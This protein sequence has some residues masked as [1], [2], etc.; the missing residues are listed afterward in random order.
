MVYPFLCHQ[1]DH[2]ISKKL[3]KPFPDCLHD[4]KTT[5][6]SLTRAIFLQVWDNFIYSANWQTDIASPTCNLIKSD[7]NLLLGTSGAGDIPSWL[8]QKSDVPKMASA[9][10]KNGRSSSSV[11]TDLI[12]GSHWIH[13][14]IRSH[15]SRGRC[16]RLYGDLHIDRHLFVAK[17]DT[18]I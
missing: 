9:D 3:S 5:L 7:V 15:I 10:V 13:F 16:C 4:R 1:F 12:L 2:V 18:K 17:T 6:G 11:A 14:A 8:T